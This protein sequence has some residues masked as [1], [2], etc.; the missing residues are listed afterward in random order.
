MTGK[1]EII[2]SFGLQVGVANEIDVAYTSNSQPMN[3]GFRTGFRRS[4]SRVP[5]NS[6][7]MDSKDT[8]RLEVFNGWCG[9]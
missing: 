5:S 3:I 1:L 7:D 6:P 4:M 9:Q 2:A 8:S